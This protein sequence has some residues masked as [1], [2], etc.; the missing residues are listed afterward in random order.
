VA[1]FFSTLTS[2]QAIFNFYAVLCWFLLEKLNYKSALNQ[3]CIGWQGEIRY[4][5]NHSRCPARMMTTHTHVAKLQQQLWKTWTTWRV[6]L[7]MSQSITQSGIFL[8]RRTYSLRSTRKC[9]LCLSQTLSS[10]SNLQ[11]IIGT[12]LTWNYYIMGLPFKMHV[13]IL[14]SWYQHCYHYLKNKNSLI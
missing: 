3:P 6:H 14:I 13:L 10:L 8:L 2:H 9:T 1:S 4:L 11:K 5:I 7:N 12:Y